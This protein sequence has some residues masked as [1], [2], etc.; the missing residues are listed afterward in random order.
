[1]VILYEFESLM[2]PWGRQYVVKRWAG[3]VPRSD[4]LIRRWAED[5]MEGNSDCTKV[6]S[7]SA[8]RFVDDDPSLDNLLISG[9][10]E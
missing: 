10:S 1:M 6:L 4:Y 7:T 3:S 5:Y 9:E 2:A 8:V